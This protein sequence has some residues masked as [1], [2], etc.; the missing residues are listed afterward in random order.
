MTKICIAPVAGGRVRKPGGALLAV[1]GEM[2]EAGVYWS[3]RLMHGD[4]VE[5]EAPVETPVETPAA[6]ETGA[7]Q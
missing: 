3:R 5:I 4:V 2:V 7:N 6:T 1:G